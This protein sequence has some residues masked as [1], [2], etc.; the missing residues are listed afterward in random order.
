MGLMR[1]NRGISEKLR[2]KDEYLRLIV[3]LA[4]DYDG[5]YDPE[6]KRGNIESMAGIIDELVDYEKLALDND[7][8]EI[9]FY[10]N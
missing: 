9:P 8:T 1:K 4:G 5:F 2:I 3:G 10:D 6:T 7:P